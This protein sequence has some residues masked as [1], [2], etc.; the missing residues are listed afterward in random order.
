MRKLA[1]I[2]PMTTFCAPSTS[3]RLPIADGSPPKCRCQNEYPSSTTSLAPGTSSSG[4]KSRPSIGA[5]PSTLSV[6]CEICAACTRSGSPAPV[7]LFVS[8]SYTPTRSKKCG[9][10]VN[11][12]YSSYDIHDPAFSND[13]LHTTAVCAGSPKGSGASSAACTTLNNAVVAPMPRARVS[14]AAIAKPGAPMRVRIA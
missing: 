12:S 14:A 4:R 1:G 7:T 9:S 6:G 2:T 3:M 11:S 10:Y 13:P 5:T 8:M